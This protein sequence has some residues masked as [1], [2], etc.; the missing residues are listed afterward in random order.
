[1]MEEP[2]IQPKPRNVGGMNT[3]LKSNKIAADLDPLPG[4][5]FDLKA[6]MDCKEKEDA[7]SKCVI[8]RQRFTA[9][10]EHDGEKIMLTE[11]DCFDMMHL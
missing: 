9:K 10:D 8:C 2:P 1:M 3:M 11:T 5:S 7:Y 6:Y 4:A